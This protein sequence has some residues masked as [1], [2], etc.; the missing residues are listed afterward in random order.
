M[1][2]QIIK[3]W[4]PNHKREIEWKATAPIGTGDIE[5]LRWGQPGTCINRIEYL[6]HSNRLFVCGDL[7]EAVYGGW[8]KGYPLEWIANLD[9]SYF[10]SKCECSETGREY[11]EW[12]EEKARKHL[13]E[14]FENYEDPKEQLTKARDLGAFGAIY[15]ENEWVEFM[16][17]YGYEAFGDE[18]YELG[19]IGRKI[20]I[21]CQG[22]LI[23]LKLAFGL[24]LKYIGD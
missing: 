4:F 17:H 11:F 2:E 5:F 23:G 20:N 24:P 16:S 14:H 7:G 1:K 12:S 18:Y 8:D 13:N 9:L 15:S 19:R 10:A 22:H 21:R 3:H 6:R